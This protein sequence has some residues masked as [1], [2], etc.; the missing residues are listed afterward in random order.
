MGASCP[1]E[2]GSIHEGTRPFAAEADATGGANRYNVR[3]TVAV[4]RSGL[5]AETISFSC[6]ILRSLYAD[7]ARTTA[8]ARPARQILTAPIA[9]ES[10]IT[11]RL[12]GTV[13]ESRQQ[14]ASLFNERS[15]DWRE[16]EQSLYGK[17]SRNA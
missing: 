13:D 2:S 14:V 9:D 12:V 3:A 15:D 11:S 5:P 4:P 7:T 17:R 1:A 8:A 6:S 16:V 10:S